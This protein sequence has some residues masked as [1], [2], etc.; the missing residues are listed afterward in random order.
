MHLPCLSRS[1]LVRVA[2]LIALGLPASSQALLDLPGLPGDRLG[3]SV[4]GVGD[5]DGDGFPDVLVGADQRSKRDSLPS[6]TRGSVAILSGRT[7][8][9]LFHLTGDDYEA[10]TGVAP[11][12]AFGVDVLMPGDLDQDGVGDVLVTHGN[13]KALRKVAAFSTATGAFLFELVDPH[14]HTDFGTPL[15]RLGDVFDALGNPVPDGISDFAVCAPVNP[16]SMGLS[17]YPGRVYL[18]SGASAA[19]GPVATLFGV[20]PRIGFGQSATLVGDLDG[21]GIP[22]FVVG[23]MSGSYVDVFDGPGYASLY[24]WAGPF[25][26]TSGFGSTL[27]HLGDLD[28]DGRDELAVGAP[29]ARNGEGRVVVYS[30]DTVGATEFL[31][32]RPELPT[33]GLGFGTGIAGLPVDPSTGLGLLDLDHDGQPDPFLDW[34]HDQRAD[35]VIGAATYSLPGAAG[36]GGIFF[37]TGKNS[38]V[39]L[40][41]SIVHQG[42]ASA[43][44]YSYLA[45]RTPRADNR[46]G[47]RERVVLLGQAAG[48]SQPRLAL[49]TPRDETNNGHVAV[50][51]LPFAHFDDDTFSLA[52]DG[53]GSSRELTLDFGPRYAGRVFYL[54]AS[55]AGAHPGLDLGAFTLPLNDDGPQGLLARTSSLQANGTP[56]AFSHLSGFLDSRGRSAITITVTAPPVGHPWFAGPRQDYL[57]VVAHPTR[58]MRLSVVGAPTPLHIE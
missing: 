5:Y 56:L 15:I 36:A 57:A 35:F 32:L 47:D 24:S 26:P 4:Q 40:A 19:G 42:L 16:V 45:S 49:G 29:G 3:C 33:P 8:A 54:L 58:P 13:P 7:G 39:E 53:V 46:L 48:E 30:L 1:D 34:N 41:R 50:L 37:V 44:G 21:D 10:R 31:R 38:P 51:R 14:G 43:R 20:A 23:T 2:A 17:V 55:S 27:A 22:A 18:F 6:D 28:G 9:V 25:L 11:E 52:N 12:V